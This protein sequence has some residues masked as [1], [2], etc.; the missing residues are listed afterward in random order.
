RD[1]GQARRALKFGKANFQLFKESVSRSP[2]ET[3][4]R[5]KGAGQSW[6]IFEDTFHG[7]QELSIP[8]CQKSGKQ[9]KRPAWRSRDLLG[10]LKGKKELHRQW[11]QGQVLWEEHRDAARIRKAKVQ[12]ELNWARDAK[13]NDGLLQVCQPE[14]ED[15]R[16]CTPAMSKTGELVTDEEKAE[17]LNNISASVFTGNLSSHTSRVDGPQDRHQGSKASPALREDQV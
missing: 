4:L 16:K 7:V 6:Q 9:G 17:V 11:K 2:W 13:D 12:L 5:D 3:A 15:Q 1:M 14:K 10:K 8:R